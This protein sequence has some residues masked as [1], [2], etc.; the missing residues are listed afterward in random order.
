MYDQLAVLA[1]IMLAMTAAT[2]IF[3]GTYC[4]VRTALYALQ[5]TFATFMYSF[6]VNFIQLIFSFSIPQTLH[7]F[8]H[9]FLILIGPYLDSILTPY[10]F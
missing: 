3:K 9:S 7:S 4:S 5:C 2:P 10:L 6:A 8:F 1:P